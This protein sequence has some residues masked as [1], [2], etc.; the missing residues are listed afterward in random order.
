MSTIDTL[1]SLIHE[2]FDI[3]PQSI[4]EQAPFDSYNLDSLTLA[5]LIFAIEDKFRLDIPELP[6][7]DIRTLAQL[8]ALVDR[9]VAERGVEVKG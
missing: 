6:T 8:A 3:D 1:K 2:Q 5:E 7:S 4:D 9:L